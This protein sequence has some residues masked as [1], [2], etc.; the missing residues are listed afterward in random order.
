V[1]RD[2]TVLL[3]GS[4]AREHAIAWKLA[5]SKRLKNL[6]AAPGSDAIAQWA[7]CLQIDANDPAAVV[8][9][10]K[11]AHA[12]LVFIGPEAPLAQGVSD[13]LRKEGFLVFGPSQAAAR[14]ET[15]KA[16]AKGFMKRHGIPTAEFQLFE[17]AAKARAAASSWEGVCVV[18]ADGLAAGKGVFVCDDNAAAM[19]AVDE[20]M[21]RKTL[22][23]S[24][25]TVV[26]E[27]GLTGPEVSVL[28][29]VDGTDFR[30]LPASQD[31][32]RLLDGDAGPNTGGMGAYAPAGMSPALREKIARAVFEPF[33]RGLAAEK[34]DYRGVVFAGL[35]LTPS[36]PMTLE[37]NCRFGDPETQAILPILD[38]D[39]LEL[40]LDCAQGALGGRAPVP[41]TG[42]A[43]VGVTL[44]SEGYPNRPQTGRPIDGLDRLPEGA[45]AFH[46]GTRREGDRWVTTGGR[47]LTICA[48]AP[49]V[50]QARERAYAAVDEVAFAGLQRRRDI[51]AKELSAA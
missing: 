17:D 25:E 14:L 29:L 50:A 41:S 43:C 39:L 21:V 10:A 32:K 9:A 16:F 42:A 11:E 48:S 23:A 20:L 45:L 1:T 40:A 33:I 5:K 34:L 3:L 12:K 2:T 27:K 26:L 24:G 4:G 15:S 47:V 22:G 44:A 35:M 30:L 13:A 37:F 46:A 49:T 36:G 6:Y 7:Q 38:A 18:K 51:A 8:A 19:A 28:A 31:H